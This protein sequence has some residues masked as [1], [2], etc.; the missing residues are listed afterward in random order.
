MQFYIDIDVPVAH[1][2]QRALLAQWPSFQQ[3]LCHSLK[4][5]GIITTELAGRT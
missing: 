5:I 4:V 2:N 3:L 1:K